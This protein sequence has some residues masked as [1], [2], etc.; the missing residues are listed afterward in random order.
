MWRNLKFGW[1]LFCGAVFISACTKKHTA[2]PLFDTLTANSTGLHFS[3]ELKPSPDFNLFSY[4]YYYNGAGVGVGDV[5]NDGLV[6]I[7]FA[8][9]QQQNRLYL[10]KGNMVFEDVTSK[11]NIPED[12]LWSTGVSM[13]DINADGL[14]DIYVCRVSQYKILRGSNQLLICKGIDENGTPFYEDEAAAYGLDFSGFST[15]AAFLDYDLDGDLDLFLLNHSVNHDGNYAPRANFINTMDSLAGHRMFRNDSKTMPDGSFVPL[16]TDVTNA[17]GINSSRIGYGLGIAVSDINLDGLPDIYVGNDFHENDYL[18]INQGDGTFIEEGTQR[19]K[20]TSQFSMGVDAADINNDG[21]PD[22]VSMDM[23]PNDPYMIRRS[24]SE[25]AYDIFQHKLAYGYSHQYARNNLQ[26]NMRNGRFSEIGQLAGIQ[27][28]DWSWSAMLMDFDNDG[29]KDLFV[30][31]GIPKR[32]NDIDYIN[33][34]SGEA[35]Q[36]KLRNDGIEDGDLALIEKFPEIKLPNHF[37]NNNGALRF[38]DIT[39]NIKSNLPTFS[40]GA[41][42]ADFDNDG[43]LDIVVNN[44]NDKAIIYRNNTNKDSSTAAFASFLL[45][46]TKANTS[47]IGAKL[48]VWNQGQVRMY[49]NQ[50]VHGFLSSMH[51]P[52]HIGLH[53]SEPDSITIVWPDNSFENID[54]T[55]GKL[56]NI[57]YKN[58]LPKFNYAVLRQWLAPVSNLIFTDITNAT[59]LDFKHIENPFNEFDRESLMPKMLSTEGPALATADINGDG[60]EDIFI[61][62]SKTNV[63]AVWLQKPNGRFVRM[64]QPAL[65]ADS[66]WEHVDAQWADL[67]GDHF[68]DLIIA[69]GGNEY[70]GNDPHLQPLLYLNDGTGLLTKNESA[71]ENVFVTQS[72][73]LVQDFTGDGIPDLFI[74]GR[75]IPWRYGIAPP[76]F[77]LQNDGKGHFTDVTKSWCPELQTAGFVTDAL[78]IDLNNDNKP[79]LVLCYEWGGIDAFYHDGKSFRQSALSKAS[80]WWQCLYAT[81]IDNDGDTD[82]IVGN[83]GLNHRLKA[84]EKQPVRLYVNDFDGN[85]RIEQILTYYLKGTEIPLATK[86]TLEKQ[87]PSLKKKYLYAETFAKARLKEMFDKEKWNTS[88]QWKANYFSNAVLINDGNGNFSLQPLPLM[89]QFSTIR[90]IMKVDANGDALPDYLVLGNFTEYNIELGRQDANYGTLLINRGQGKF[91][92]EVIQG[93]LIDGEVRKLHPI[94]I[95]NRLALALAQNNAPMKI[96]AY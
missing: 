45:T 46:G 11:A 30:S 36:T 9:N 41:A 21:W 76:S 2:P 13:V 4:M 43:D 73:V 75:A 55:P 14:L 52:L 47:A 91:D 61:G 31:N 7:F 80:G 67:N 29:F 35:L 51:I 22:I 78:F 44:I 32:M 54:W 1:A 92:A 6:D 82:F 38:E 68:P 66:M 83:Y 40:N 59:G 65:Q 25:D 26:L 64:A 60:L 18:Y 89:A 24:L 27:A 74:A 34:V 12:S 71:F 15:H 53:Q 19:L 84:T 33:F 69:T 3:N 42:F 77:L 95:G 8:A 96:I 87:M 90:C 56:N 81:D 63:A 5:N 70:Y 93:D 86:I 88:I 37:F 28:T 94:T 79:D 72:K 10:N 85:G 23:L 39:D 62:G 58:D 20:H 17:T 57:S 50:P 16:F 48:L 49:E